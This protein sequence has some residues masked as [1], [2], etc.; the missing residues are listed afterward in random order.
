MI[1]KMK[2]KEK[3]INSK[4]SKKQKQVIVKVYSDMVE[5]EAIE[6]VH[7]GQHL[8]AVLFPKEEWKEV[9]KFVENVWKK[10]DHK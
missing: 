9:E 1:R 6:I 10:E 4:F 2:Y 3:K 5:F 7:D 8:G